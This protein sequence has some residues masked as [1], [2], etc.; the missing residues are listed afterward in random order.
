MRA[1]NVNV[2][3]SRRQVNQPCNTWPAQQIRPFL[4]M[5]RSIP[6]PP[7]LTSPFC[8]ARLTLT[9]LKP[10]A[11]RGASDEPLRLRLAARLVLPSVPL[12]MKSASSHRSPAFLSAACRTADGC[13]SHCPAQ[14]HF[15]VFRRRLL[16]KRSI[17][18]KIRSGNIGFSGERDQHVVPIFENCPDR[19]DRRVAIDTLVSAADRFL[20]VLHCP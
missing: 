12:V 2:M 4:S 8:H 5:V 14:Q 17:R 20:W 10:P 1:V 11:C 6:A 16:T 9:L 13:Q 19:R 15:A 18:G 7:K 3:T